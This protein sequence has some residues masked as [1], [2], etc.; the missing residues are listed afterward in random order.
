M[1]KNDDLVPKEYRKVKSRKQ[2]QNGV[3]TKMESTRSSPVS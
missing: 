2:K 3:H 1:V